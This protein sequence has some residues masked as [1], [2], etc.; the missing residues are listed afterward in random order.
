MRKKYLSWLNQCFCAFFIKYVHQ[1]ILPKTP[2]Y[3]ICWKMIF[4][5]L[6]RSSIF[7]EYIIA[8][9]SGFHLE[10]FHSG[11][12]PKG[13]VS[14]IDLPFGEISFYRKFRVSS[15]VKFWTDCSW[16]LNIQVS[17]QYSPTLFSIDLTQ[18]KKPAGFIRII[19]SFFQ[20]VSRKDWAWLRLIQVSF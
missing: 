13:R 18:A 11:T 1:F 7:S 5:D 6:W 17:K 12:S 4:F 9:F 16:S 14:K 8:V 2:Y 20:N 15:V 19:Y 3:I 10:F